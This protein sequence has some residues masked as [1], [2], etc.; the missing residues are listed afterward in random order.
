[1]WGL[2]DEIEK[3]VGGEAGLWEEGKDEEP[4]PGLRRRN[5]YRM[6]STVCELSP[7]CQVSKTHPGSSK[8]QAT[9]ELQFQLQYLAASP[10]LTVY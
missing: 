9:N 2:V 6:R 3:A 4:R 8:P 7:I 1:M 10:S 5:R